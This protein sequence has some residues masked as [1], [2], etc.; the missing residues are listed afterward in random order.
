VTEDERVGGLTVVAGILM[1]LVL[2]WS[3][4]LAASFTYA[5]LS[6]SGHPSLARSTGYLVIALFLALLAART[7]YEM[8][9]RLGAGRRAGGSA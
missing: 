5:A 6:R 1:T 8:V 7:A 4:G 3:G 9:R 2:L